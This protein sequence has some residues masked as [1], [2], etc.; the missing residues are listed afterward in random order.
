[1]RSVSMRAGA[2]ALLTATLLA[3]CQTT[4]PYT[5][6]PQTSK[7]TTGAAVGAVAGAVVGLATGDDA[8]ERRQHALIGAGI[9]G[10]SGAA[11]GNYMDR[12]EAELRQRLRNSGVSV[13]RKGDRIILNMPGNVTFATDSADLRSQFFDVLDSVSLV[14]KE[15]EKTVINVAGHTD[16]TGPADY[17]QRLSERRAQTVADYL[18][19]RGINSQR[20]IARGYGEDYPIASNDTEQGRQQNRRVTLELTPL[21][22]Q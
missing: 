21:R 9:G 3:G 16:S 19:N 4:D 17:N 8:T 20:I 1:M 13:T 7:T 15:Y 11:I 6:E 18:R 12:Q 2:F 14:L 5:G 22:A 10:L